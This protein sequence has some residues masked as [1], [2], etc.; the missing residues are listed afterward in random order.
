MFVPSLSWQNDLTYIK[1]QK[2]YRFLT[3]YRIVQD[4]RQQNCPRNHPDRPAADVRHGA[5]DA[6]AASAVEENRVAF[7]HRLRGAAESGVEVD[8]GGNAVAGVEQS[9]T[10]PPSLL[11]CVPSLSWQM[12]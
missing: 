11:A 8:S 3:W 1:R 2:E 12:K 4:V 6:V 10:L 9:N 5:A 7:S